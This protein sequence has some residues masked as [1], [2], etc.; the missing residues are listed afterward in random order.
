MWVARQARGSSLLWGPLCQEVAGRLTS[1]NRLRTSAWT[2]CVAGG[3]GTRGTR[4]T[5]VSSAC[6]WHALEGGGQ[7]GGGERWFTY[8][9]GDL[10]AGRFS[11]PMR[12]AQLRTVGGKSRKQDT[13]G[14]SYVHHAGQGT[15]PAARPS[16]GGRGYTLRTGEHQA[17]EGCRQGASAFNRPHEQQ[18]RQ[19]RSGHWALVRG[20]PDPVPPPWPSGDGPTASPRSHSVCRVSAWRRGDPPL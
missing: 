7:A 3:G 1:Q 4:N 9:T 13:H 20:E 12:P 8:T 6:R 17:G 15:P 2:V 10:E 16:R 14:K 18:P 11:F 19:S 5:G